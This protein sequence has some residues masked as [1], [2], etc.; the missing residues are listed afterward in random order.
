LFEQA[1]AKLL[2]AGVELISSHA[3]KDPSH[4]DDEVREAI[5]GGRRW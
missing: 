2:A 3:V 5:G 4:L 1:C